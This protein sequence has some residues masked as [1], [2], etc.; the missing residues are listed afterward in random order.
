M[1][2]IRTLIKSALQSDLSGVRVKELALSIGATY[3]ATYQALQS[4][5]SEGQVD[6]VARGVFA[7]SEI[8]K[9][10]TAECISLLQSLENQE[11][12]VEI[13]R[14]ELDRAEAQL[15]AVKRTIKSTMMSAFED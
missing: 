1:A 4:M 3:S 10:T 8:P 9:F 7:L 14:E 5:M 11:I 15:R 12:A 13:A 2:N 6:K